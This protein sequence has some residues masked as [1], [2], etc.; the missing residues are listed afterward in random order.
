MNKK[1]FTLIELLVVI[2]IIG[3][4]SSIIFVS[5]ASARN[6]ARDAAIKLSLSQLRN[7]GGLYMNEQDTYLGF[8]GSEKVLKV[9]Q[10]V[11]SNRSN[12]ICDSDLSTAW[13]A[14]AQLVADVSYYC[15]VDSVGNSAKTFGTCSNGAVGSN[16]CFICG[17][18]ILDPFEQCDDGNLLDGDGCSSTCRL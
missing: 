14:C 12:L 5:L 15:C 7:A 8:C 10:G 6:K 2:S 4:L 1:A 9:G 11:S 13:A 3:L 17:N 18:G 16:K